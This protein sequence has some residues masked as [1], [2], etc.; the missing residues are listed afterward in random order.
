MSYDTNLRAA[1]AALIKAKGRHHSEQSYKDLV[2]AFNAPKITPEMREAMDKALAAG[3][4]IAEL[5]DGHLMFMNMG[6]HCEEAEDLLNCPTC[7]GC[8]YVDEAKPDPRYDARCA[9]MD[10]T[11]WSAA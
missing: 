7:G 8:G 6:D 4:L 2:E 3:S 5:P 1:V 9:L 10:K 11:D